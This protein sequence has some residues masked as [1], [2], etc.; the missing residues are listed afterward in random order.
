M[1]CFFKDHLKSEIG[2]F[3]S[4]ILL[5]ILESSNS[6]GQQKLLTVQSLRTAGEI[7]TGNLLI[8]A[9]YPLREIDSSHRGAG[10]LVREPQ[11]IV[12]LF[13]EPTRPSWQHAS[14]TPSLHA[15]SSRHL[16]TASV[17]A[18]SPQ[19]DSYAMLCYAMLCYAMQCYAMPCYAMLCYAMLCR[20]TSS[21]TTTATSRA[22]RSSRRHSIA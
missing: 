12:E 10:V 19:V 22:K 7:R 13:L 16:F 20:S 15:I 3:F 2:V 9:Y 5:R 6:S 21:S 14:C 11:L 1:L 17:R 8:P 18:L 4:N